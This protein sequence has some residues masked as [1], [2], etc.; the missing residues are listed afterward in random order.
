MKNRLV[1]AGFPLRKKGLPFLCPMVKSGWTILLFIVGLPCL[2]QASLD[3][4][5]L[6][7]RTEQ[8]YRDKNYAQFIEFGTQLAEASGDPG[9]FYRLAEAHCQTGD[10]ARAIQYLKKLASMQVTYPVQDNPAL[11]IL[12][13]NK[14]FPA[15]VRQFGIN[16]RPVQRSQRAFT[17]TDKTLIPEGI[18][19]DPLSGRF[20][21]GSLAQDKIIV[22]DKRGRNK[23]FI[24]RGQDGIWQVLGMKVDPVRKDLWVCSASERDTLDGYAGVFRY[25][26]KSGK[27]KKKYTVDNKGGLHLFNDLVIDPKGNVFL[28]DSKAGK[29]Y[30]ITTR[31]DSLTPLDI[32]VRFIYPNGLALSEGEKFLFVADFTGLTKVDLS[33]RHVTK[34]TA[35]GVTYLNWIDGM[36][37]H[38]NSLIVIQNPGQQADR[39]ARLYLDSQSER[40]IRSE[41]LQSF[42]PHFNI[43]TTGTFKGNTFYYI[44]NSQLRNLKPDGTITTPESLKE[45][46]ILKLNLEKPK[47]EAR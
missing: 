19:Y 25:D 12:K 35:E 28:T 15:L 8:A 9:M 20:F 43:P 47:E 38:A 7:T 26:L 42:H 16:A 39:V 11:S 14:A 37:F 40:I 6:F 36:Y 3:E 34:I 17:I 31:S 4:L 45:V 24:R 13:S 30:T 29:V 1:T 18:A 23:D 2:A 22:I 10:T 5:D 41:V 33:N 44:A 27:L 21:I 46:V 32:P